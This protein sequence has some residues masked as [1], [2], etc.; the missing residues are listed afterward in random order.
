[1]LAR[2]EFDSVLRNTK[3]VEQKCQANRSSSK[4]SRTTNTIFIL[5]FTPPPS[6]LLAFGHFWTCL[7]IMKKVFQGMMNIFYEKFFFSG[8]GVD[9]GT[10]PLI[11]FLRPPFV[12]RYY[13][14]LFDRNFERRINCIKCRIILSS[15]SNSSAVIF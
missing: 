8:R 5:G 9:K 15:A 2:R 14:Q 1:M 7:V 12:T 4:G 3:T 10:E 11:F 6:S 13:I